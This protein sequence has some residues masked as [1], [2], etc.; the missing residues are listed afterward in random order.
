MRLITLN[1]WGGRVSAK[2]GPFFK[3]YSSTDIWCFQEVYNLSPNGPG[4]DS[5]IKVEGYEPDPELFPNLKHR[6]PTHRG[7]FCPTYKS[8]YG[9]ATFVRGGIEIIDMGEMLV[10]AG[11]W[12]D[13][14]DIATKDHHRKLQWME[15][16]IDQK[17]L[18]LVNAHL[19]HRPAGKQDS[20]KRLKQ[21]R[22]IVDFLDM[23]NMPKI[24]AGD[25][26]LLPDT[27]SVQMIEQAGVRNLIK[28]YSITSTRTELYKKDLPFADYIFTSPEIK[29]NEFKV[30][31]ETVSDHS[32][33]SLDFSLT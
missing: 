22:L 26:N 24:V 12:N 16:K 7:E 28:D 2:L 31:P 10:A 32:A 33:L 30:L 29:V 19:T 4:A 13:N 9:L 5:M 23:F 27:E 1:I 15:L 25:F 8:V 6:L 18:L 17:Y 21:S 14:A 11:D 20:E 3:T